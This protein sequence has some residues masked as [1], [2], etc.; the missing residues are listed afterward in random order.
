MFP[1]TSRRVFGLRHSLAA[2]RWEALAATGV[3]LAAAVLFF[4]RLG[5]R[6]VVSEE[7]RW[8]EVAR[9]M[10]L[11]GDY[12]HPTING[13]TY[14]DKP[15]GS[16]WLIVAASYLTG[17]VNET[18][19]RLPA[20]VAGWLGVLLVM[21]LGRRLYDERTAVLAGAVL[22]SSFGLAFYARRATAD[23]ETVTG[24]LAAVWLFAR[25]RD[26]PGGA[27]V[28]GLWLLMAATSLTKG[29]LGFALPGVVFVVYGT[30][31]VRIEGRSIFAGNRWLF[32]RWTLLAAPLG[33]AVY[34]LPFALSMWESGAADG[35]QMVWR[36]NIRR[37]FTPHNHTGPV[38]LYAGV[39]FLLAAPW[40][41]FLPAA[42]MPPP[43]Q[44]AT[45]GDRL[46]RA[47]FWAV[48][49]FF[50]LSASRR[51]YYLLPV[52]PAVA[53]LIGRVLSVS[54]DELRPLARRLR[55]GGY[56]T[57]FALIALAGLGLLAPADVLPTPYNQLPPLPA[58]WAIALGWLIGLAALVWYGR[59]RPLALAIGAAFVSLGY[60]LLAALP[61]T[62]AYR[63]R[64]DFAAEV[65]ER[66]AAEP[67]RLALFHARD[68][69]FD[70]RPSSP[71][72]AYQ[73]A[74][75]LTAAVRDGRVRWVLA[76]R[77]YLALVHLP[78]VPVA[79]EAVQPWE[80]RDQIGDKMVLLAV[81]D[82][83][84]KRR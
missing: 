20:A 66:I 8:A 83:S 56:V 45:D 35:L 24:V 47:F 19:A 49:L 82:T 33:V 64:K 65:R 73:T 22:A 42:L 55:R 21:A 6:G 36:E 12:L 50:T 30:W 31:S 23:V 9:E 84:Q 81:S 43:R 72:P 54:A 34:F 25:H 7:L 38:Y 59:R 79:D 14:Y 39:I 58:R 15:V 5:G 44:N 40:S 11:S 26:R 51:S 53:L 68:V 2:P 61:A 37:F 13:R 52:L 48:F 70:L 10:R 78:A 46:A 3:L 4:A 29:L 28:V 32:N 63:T 71:I 60:V 27:W 18:A 16:Y 17:E 1:T 57:V 69:V 75:E 74:E 76:R 41:A 62:E 80:G 77:R 67:N